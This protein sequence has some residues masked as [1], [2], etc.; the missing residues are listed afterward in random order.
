MKAYSLDL[1]AR[2]AAA[3]QLPDATLPD[4]AQQFSVSLSFVE[5]LRRHLRQT[6]SLAA[7]AGRCR[8]WMQPPASN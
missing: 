7:G 1:R 2:V 4:V 5:K 8:A 3:C 6:G